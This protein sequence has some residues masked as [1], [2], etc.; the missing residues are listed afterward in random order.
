MSLLHISVQKRYVLCTGFEDFPTLL[1]R[2]PQMPKRRHAYPYWHW[3]NH[4]A[5]N[6]GL[7]HIS[8]QKTYVFCTGFEN[9][10][11]LLERTP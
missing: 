2:T 5:E 10:P 11:A 1:A 7:L 8:V 6:M 3:P 9:F 4:C